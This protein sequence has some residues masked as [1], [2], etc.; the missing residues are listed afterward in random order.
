MILSARQIRRISATVVYTG[1]LP[2]L[3]SNLICCGLFLSVLCI[4][5]D[6]SNFQIGLVNSIPNIVL[7]FQ[8]ISAFLAVYWGRRKGIFIAAAL[9]SR[10]LVF[11]LGFLIIMKTG[12]GNFL[13]N[14]LFIILFFIIHL[15][16]SLSVPVWFSWIGDLVPQRESAGFWGK[17]NAI[18]FVAA[19]F[20]SLFIG[21]SL[22][23]GKNGSFVISV[24]LFAGALMSLFEIF[25]YF[26]I[27]KMEAETAKEKFRPF[28]MI[29]EALSDY[30][31]RSFISYY[32]FF[33]FICSFF[34]AFFYIYLLKNLGYSNSLIQ[35]YAVFSSLASF[36]GSY[37]W[38]AIAA[39]KGNKP[40]IIITTLLKT[41]EFT[42]FLFIREGTPL[43][44]PVF[45]FIYGGFLN[46]GLITAVFAILTAETP[47]KNRSVFMA[48]FFS[49]AGLAGFL[50]ALF[51]GVCMDFFANS[52][53]DLPGFSFSGYHFIIMITALSMPVCAL[54]LTPYRAGP[55]GSAWSTVTTFLEGNPL[56]TFFRLVD[57]TGKMSF[58]DRLNFISRNRSSLF[59]PE[60]IEALDDPAPPVRYSAVNSLGFI[61]HADSEKAL[62]EKLEDEES[63]LATGA[64][65]SL[66]RLK[67]LKAVPSL[68]KMLNSS[69][70]SV[71]GGA[72][73]ALGEIK[74]SASLEPLKEAFIKEKNLFLLAAIA[75][76]L[77][78]FDDISVITLIF[79]KFREIMKPS[80][81][82][83]FCVALA[84]VVGTV[85]EF[86]NFLLREKRQ[87]GSISEI[88]VERI[89]KKLPDKSEDIKILEDLLNEFDD[90]DYDEFIRIC[91]KLGFKYYCP[92]IKYDK[93][94][95][96]NIYDWTY[97]DF[98][99]AADDKLLSENLTVNYSLWLLAIL[100][101]RKFEEEKTT[102][103]EALLA[104]Y[105]LS[106][107]F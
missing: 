92:E 41:F 38:S 84:N 6:L 29:R 97:E 54:L 95:S 34:I 55:E 32:S 50:G 11:L 23:I 25:F 53:I 39:Q 98:N 81:R 21:L 85:G 48:L 14:T 58:Q 18:T 37:F 52:R 28:G 67:S 42:G 2:V 90:A 20:V 47:Q 63:G 69:E 82:M 88:F 86:Y 64:A 74:D 66:G 8:L 73:F 4:F 93:M 71:R 87:P 72:A 83:Q 10:S 30:N 79:P 77:G 46:A 89:K 7:P 100:R 94:N 65:Y 3:Y 33:T 80:I 1:A 9:L 104:L 16:S 45:V 78:K 96:K 35:I 103:E 57:V 24:L 40:V 70:K 19:I 107:I 101:Y 91:F 99:K 61:K 105:I 13:I 51:S 43:W 12:G 60:V 44:M 62:M 76:A 102:C 49:I 75:D 26:G 36:L 59:L 106:K 27:P 17:R 22:D 31:F 68:L 5:L 56:R 15:F